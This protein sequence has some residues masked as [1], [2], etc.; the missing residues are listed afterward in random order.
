MA[1][2]PIKTWDKDHSSEVMDYVLELLIPPIHLLQNSKADRSE[3]IHLASL[4][5]NQKIQEDNLL[6][7]LNACSAKL[8][9][10]NAAVQALADKLDANT[11]VTGLD[12]NYGSTTALKLLQG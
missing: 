1:K 9:K 7:A 5:N 11:A 4:L 10:L 12:R 6:I 3:L 8:D 2:K